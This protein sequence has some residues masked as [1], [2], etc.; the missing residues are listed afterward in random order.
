MDHYSYIYGG[1]W[2]FTGT[3]KGIRSFARTEENTFRENGIWGDK[4][5]QSIMAILNGKLIAVNEIGKGGSVICYEIQKD[6][7]LLECCAL[8]LGFPKLSYVVA[9][10]LLNYVYVSSMGNGSVSMIRVEADGHLELTDQIRLTGHSVTPRQQC[11]KVHSVMTSPDGTLL[12]AANL[13]ADEIDLFRIDH[14]AEKLYFLSSIPID[15]GQSPRHMAFHPNGKYL[16]LLTETGNRIYVIAV[17]KEGLS[18]LAAYNTL[19]QG[20]TQESSAADILVSRDGRYVYSTNRGQNNIAVWRVEENGMLYL[21]GFYGCGGKGPRGICFS[22]D[23]T[24]LLS[25]NYDSG[26][27]VRLERDLETGAIG[28]VLETLTV[29]AAGCVRVI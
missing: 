5:G 22:P 24:E 10:R 15:F 13:G 2:D 4:G 16:Y 17:G 18:I 9:D 21:C 3:I 27:V 14:K 11:A 1:D 23:E 25:A 6:G 7:T 19:K 8:E 26:T 28:N 29:P 12:A 20:E